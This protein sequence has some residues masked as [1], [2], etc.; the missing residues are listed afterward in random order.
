[1]E[2]VPE[3]LVGV[4]G[5][6]VER[7]RGQLGLGGLAIPDPLERQLLRIGTELQI[8]ALVTDD[9]QEGEPQDAGVVRVALLL[10]EPERMRALGEPVAHEGA[11]LRQR[12]V[13]Q[14]GAAS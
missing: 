13:G 14:D 4:E 8:A 11:V 2:T 3:R 12:V 7:G 1:M 10:G 6:E 5:R 9:A